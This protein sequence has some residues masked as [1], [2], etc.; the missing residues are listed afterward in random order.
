MKI[1]NNERI[2]FIPQ[3]DILGQKT[4]ACCLCPTWMGWM[5]WLVDGV[6]VLQAPVK[7]KDKNRTNRYQQAGL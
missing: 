2:E 5:P 6:D 1:I 7:T 4:G 3:I